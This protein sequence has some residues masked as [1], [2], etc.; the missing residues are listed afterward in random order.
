MSLHSKCTHKV[1]LNIQDL[2]L[3]NIQ[4]LVLLNIL[5]ILSKTLCVHFLC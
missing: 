3:L 4:D 5:L 1:L 2:V